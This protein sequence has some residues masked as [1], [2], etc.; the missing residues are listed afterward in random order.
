MC[1]NQGERERER[2][3]GKRAPLFAKVMPSNDAIKH[4][5]SINIICIYNVKI[6]TLEAA[7]FD[8]LRLDLK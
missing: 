2:E 8:D 4:Q 7:L 3:K 1:A 5:A 6:N